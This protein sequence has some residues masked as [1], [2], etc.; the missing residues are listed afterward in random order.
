MKVHS[1]VEGL[2]ILMK[3]DPIGRDECCIARGDLIVGGPA[4]AD[5]ESADQDKMRALGWLWSMT[6][7]SW[8]RSL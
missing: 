3:Y 2:H 5:L 6:H 1:L 8:S 7:Q 4:P